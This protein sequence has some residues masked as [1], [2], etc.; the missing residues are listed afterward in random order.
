MAKKI[1]VSVLILLG[2]VVLFLDWRLFTGDK[3]MG[4]AE[5]VVKIF[6]AS[7]STDPNFLDC[8]QVVAVERKIEGSEMMAERSLQ[9][10]LKGPNTEEKNSGYFTS[11]NSG[12]K[13]LNF[14]IT[15]KQAV[16]D[17]SGEL[18]AGVGGSCRVTS[19]RS[20]IENT[21]KQFFGIEDVLIKINGQSEDVLQP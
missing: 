1:L 11:I 19:I 18:G 8:S 5:T 10:L 2:T 6:F 3:K 15:N 21:L 7:T 16:V 20:Q 14:S 4:D 12:V 17:F 13:I 9:E